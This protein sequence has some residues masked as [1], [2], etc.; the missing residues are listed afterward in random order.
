[1]WI[2]IGW[3]IEERHSSY[4]I[5]HEDPS[6]GW[7]SFSALAFRLT[8]RDSKRQWLPAMATSLVLIGLPIDL[9]FLLAGL[10]DNTIQVASP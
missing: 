3:A 10:I 1:M 2:T 4:V 7:R 5:Y 9:L 8:S 6:I